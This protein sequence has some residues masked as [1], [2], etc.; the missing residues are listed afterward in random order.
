[1]RKEANPTAVKARERE[2][3][4]VQPAPGLTLFEANVSISQQKH[5]HYALCRAT[6]GSTRPHVVESRAAHLV[7]PSHGWAPSNIR[8]N[9][10]LTLI[11]R[12]MSNHGLLLL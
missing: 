5:V 12:A 9:P 11:V 3:E 1:M 8:P 10:T 7:S 4:A 6:H 2:A